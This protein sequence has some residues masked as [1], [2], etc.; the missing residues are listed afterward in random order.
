M[1]KGL[2]GGGIYIGSRFSS[3]TSSSSG[4]GGQPGMSSRAI[5]CML[6]PHLCCYD[7]YTLKLAVCGSTFSGLLASMV[8]IGWVIFMYV[9]LHLLCFHAS[10]S[11]RCFGC[12]VLRCIFAFRSVDTG[13]T[14]D[15]QVLLSP[16]SPLSLFMSSATNVCLPV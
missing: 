10:V 12:F 9:C 8:I 2:K 13:L 15:I 1:G 14:N 16:S 6:R 5:G 7:L 4:S 11:S 3:G